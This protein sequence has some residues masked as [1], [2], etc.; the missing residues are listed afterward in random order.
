[1]L[2]IILTYPTLLTWPFTL[3]LPGATGPAAW[4]FDARP[5]HVRGNWWLG[6]LPGRHIPFPQNRPPPEILARP[7]KL[8]ALRNLPSQMN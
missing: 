3:F 5:A 4:H 7:D 2:N 1:M 6:S 8:E